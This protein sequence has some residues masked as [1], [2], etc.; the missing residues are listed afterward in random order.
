M[1]LYIKCLIVAIYLL[2]LTVVSMW[3][4]LLFVVG[5]VIYTGVKDVY[6]YFTL[7]RVDMNDSYKFDILV[8]KYVDM[9]YGKVPRKILS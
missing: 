2:I 6:T 4:L 3:L 7:G 9:Y 5:Y 1:M 8:T